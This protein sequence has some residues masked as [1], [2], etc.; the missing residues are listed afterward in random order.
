MIQTIQNPVII[1]NANMGS[2]AHQIGRLLSS[3]TN[4]LWYDHKGNGQFPWLPC[5]QIL[6]HEISKYHFDRRFA[7]S[8]T[9]PP[10]LDFAR[11]S[12]LTEHPIIPYNRCKE[13][14][15]L[16]YITHSNLDES[17]KF[18]KGRHL[19][20]LNKDEQRFFNK[21]WNFRVGKTKELISNLYTEQEAKSMLTDT[22]ENYKEHITIND[23]VINSI[24]ELFDV[25]VFKLL[26]KRFN[27][28][29][30]KDS[31]NKVRKFLTE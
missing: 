10:A 3:C 2:K 27:L 17:R 5:S 25:E 26:C 14:Q 12:G 9:I 6:N 7:D 21:T 15:C 18:F 31:Y 16:L 24:D 28:T 19:V 20:V 23:F 11:R 13:G 4:L 30:N 1:I 22:L 29:F 8:T